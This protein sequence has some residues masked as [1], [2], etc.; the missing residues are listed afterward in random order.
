VAEKKRYEILESLP[1]YGPMY[2]P[3]TKNGEP[4]YSEGFAVRFYK[5]DGTNWVANFKPGWTGLNKV[6]DFPEHDKTII[7]AGGLGYIMT[8]ENEKPLST[9]GITINE[10]FQANNGSLVCADGIYVFV[11]DN[12]SGDIWRSDRISWDGFQNLKFKNNIISGQSYEPS[13]SME[14]WTDFS[15]N[16][17]TKELIGGSYKE[18]TVVNPYVQNIVLQNESKSKSWW[19]IW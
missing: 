9:F 5:T 17:E 4:Y 3:V 14:G 15:L 11:F 6:F 1:V 13:I 8:P 16:I 12:L 10:I 7:I 2:I 18:L 19:K